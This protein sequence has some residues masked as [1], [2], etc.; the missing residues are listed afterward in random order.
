MPKF[1]A[2]THNTQ[3][4]F[5]LQLMRSKSTGALQTQKSY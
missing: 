3:A 4:H 1:I 5:R 2:Y